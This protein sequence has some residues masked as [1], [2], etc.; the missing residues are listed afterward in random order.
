MALIATREGT[1]RGGK[2]VPSAGHGT[3]EEAA[4][5]QPRG[6]PLAEDDGR[7]GGCRCEDKGDG[8]QR[9]DARHPA[10]KPIDDATHGNA[11]C[12]RE[13]R[14]RRDAH[15]ANDVANVHVYKR[16]HALLNHG[17]TNPARLRPRN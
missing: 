3:I 12:H 13:Q 7:G 8:E 16:I 6:H 10:R 5:P 1:L 4:H 15:G 14:G 17:F 2:D 9:R 11:R